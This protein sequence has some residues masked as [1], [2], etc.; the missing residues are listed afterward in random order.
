MFRV[1]TIHPDSGRDEIAEYD[2]VP[3]LP[4]GQ[5]VCNLFAEFLAARPGEFRERLPF[6]NKGEI[7]MQ[8]AAAEGGAAYAAFFS[9]GRA[10]GMGILLSGADMEA[11]TRMIEALRVAIA[12]PM[13]G[14]RAGQALD[15]PQRP[16]VILVQLPDQPEWIPTVQLLVTALASVYFRT[17]QLAAAAPAGAP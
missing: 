2:L 13:L 10:L 5:L 6:L 11:D 16:A 12:E 1:R 8:W 17:V 9:G 15:A 14:E 7:E 3:T 4:Q